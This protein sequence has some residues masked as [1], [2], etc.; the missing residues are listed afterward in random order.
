MIRR[1]GTVLA[2]LVLIVG[3]TGCPAQDDA[4]PNAKPPVAVT[5]PPSIGAPDPEPIEKVPTPIE[6]PET[7]AKIDAEPTTIPE[8]QLPETLEQT[9]VVKLGDT[10]PEGE[11][12]DLTDEAMA[13]QAAQGKAASVVLFW[14]IGESEI[15][16]KTIA[17]TLADLQADAMDAYADRGLQVIAINVKNSAEE[18]RELLGDLELSYPILLDDGGYFAQVATE[19]L[20]RVYVLD[21][22]GK[23]VWFDLEFSEPTRRTLKETLQVMLGDPQASQPDEE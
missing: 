10:L 9:L 19:K 16:A 5:V 17:M 12:P 13:V 4:D 7:I 2:L 15:A 8:V 11:L 20:P 18:V 23:I 22:E 3:M 6:S 21:D 1:S 14:T